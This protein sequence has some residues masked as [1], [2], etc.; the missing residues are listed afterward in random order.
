MLPH[1]YGFPC[2]TQCKNYM[3]HLSTIGT[4]EVDTSSLDNS[5]IRPFDISRC[6]FCVGLVVAGY[7]TDISLTLA[8][9][10]VSR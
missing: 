9:H 8:V 4:M 7:W 1:Y 10:W 2:W 5:D 3:K 6:W